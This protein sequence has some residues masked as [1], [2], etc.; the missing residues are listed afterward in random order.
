MKVVDGNFG[1]KKRK[2]NT[3]TEVFKAL[4]EKSEGYDEIE[5]IVVTLQPGHGVL[6]HGNVGYDAA[7]ML[8]MTAQL[9]LTTEFIAFT[10]EL[11]IDVE[12]DGGDDE[13]TKH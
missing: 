6:L 2:A 12:F 7:A 9:A 8:L 10:D 11:D 5:T 1:K 3:A 13:P 4:A